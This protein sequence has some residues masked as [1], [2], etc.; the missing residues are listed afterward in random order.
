MT[1][2]GYQNQDE[3]NMGR[4]FEPTVVINT[5]SGMRLNYEQTFGPIVGIQQVDSPGEATRIINS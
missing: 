3:N 1:I 5:N 2:G 4:F